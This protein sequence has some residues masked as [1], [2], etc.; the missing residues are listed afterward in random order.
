MSEKTIY[1][2]DFDHDSQSGSLS[3][4]YDDGSY[5]IGYLENGKR[6]GYG[7]LFE[8]GIMYQGYFKNGLKH[9]AGIETL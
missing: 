5:Y 2:E 8:N 7:T 1:S 3:I 4:F 9:G 6:H